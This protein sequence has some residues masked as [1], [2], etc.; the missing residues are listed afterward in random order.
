[1][2][3]KNKEKNV[4]TNINK[5]NKVLN[6]LTKLLYLFDIIAAGFLIYSILLLSGIETKLLII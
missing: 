6:I 5:G 3:K 2:K 4:D 1:M